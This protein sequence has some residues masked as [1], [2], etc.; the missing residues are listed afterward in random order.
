MDYT[1]TVE[2]GGV[3]GR[4]NWDESESILNNIYLSLKVR[5]GSFFHNPGF[6]LLN[7]G[8]LKNTEATA[9]L[10]RHDHQE[11][12]QWLIDTGKARSIEV[13]AER[14]PHNL[15]RLKMLIEAVQADGNKVSFATFHEVI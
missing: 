11:A 6:G 10:V 8:R 4:M 15:Y 14:D 2:D 7:R 1:I 13:F 5:R 9:A 12:L 3:V